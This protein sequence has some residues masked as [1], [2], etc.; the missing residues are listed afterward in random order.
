MF[1]NPNPLVPR[2]APAS[3][4]PANSA[5]PPAFP[6]AVLAPEGEPVEFIYKGERFHIYNILSCWRESGGWWNRMSDGVSH[7]PDSADSFEIADY[8]FNDGGRSLW[9][10]EA[11]PLGTIKTFDIEFYEVTKT[12]RITPTSRPRS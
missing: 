11:A 7:L 10:V 2:P 9:R 1:E 3:S 8:L 12:W 6:P 4:I 5:M